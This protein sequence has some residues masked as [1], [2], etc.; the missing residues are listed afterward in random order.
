MNPSKTNGKL[1]GKFES[2]SVVLEVWRNPI[3]MKNGDA[4]VKDT[5]SLKERYKAK[6]EWRTTREVSL[7]NAL[8]ASELLKKA[9]DKFESKENVV[10]GGG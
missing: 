6:D 3:K 2:G 8:K 9:W 10:E 7:K 5:M 4:F 1:R